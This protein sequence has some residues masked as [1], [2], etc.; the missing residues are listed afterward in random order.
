MIATPMPS[1]RHKPPASRHRVA[2]RK[3]FWLSWRL[4]DGTVCCMMARGCH[5][6]EALT[7]AKRGFSSRRRWLRQKKGAIPGSLLAVAAAAFTVAAALPSNCLE[8][9]WWY[10]AVAGHSYQAA[11]LANSA[12]SSVRSVPCSVHSAPRSGWWSRSAG[13]K[14]NLALRWSRSADQERCW[15]WS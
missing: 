3:S 5:I 6:A 9:K 1:L 10:P 11:Y 14:A 4:S 15:G 12:S 7:S 2:E 8:E 13:S